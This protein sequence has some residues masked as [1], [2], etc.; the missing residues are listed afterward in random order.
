MLSDSRGSFMTK[1]NKRECFCSRKGTYPFLDIP[2]HANLLCIIAPF[3]YVF[4]NVQI[5]RWMNKYMYAII[6]EWEKSLMV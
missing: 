3:S 1:R 4:N 2:I 6:Y 5:P